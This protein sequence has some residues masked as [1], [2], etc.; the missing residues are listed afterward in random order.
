[1]RWKAKAHESFDS[2]QVFQESADKQGK[3]HRRLA[4]LLLALQVPLTRTFRGPLFFRPFKTTNWAVNRAL[5]A[6]SAHRCCK[7]TQEKGHG[8]D[9]A[10]NTARH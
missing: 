9:I 2:P 8:V 1:M 3:A 6:A 7:Q 10:A 4:C 5:M